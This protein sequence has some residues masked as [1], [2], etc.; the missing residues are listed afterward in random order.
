MFDPELDNFKGEIEL[1][2]YTPGGVGYVRLSA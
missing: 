1:R 2:A